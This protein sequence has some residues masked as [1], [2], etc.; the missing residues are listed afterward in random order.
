M[1]AADSAQVKQRV[2]PRR[3]QE[4]APEAMPAPQPIELN[5]PSRKALMECSPVLYSM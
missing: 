3:Q 1:A 5:F 2:G 4:D